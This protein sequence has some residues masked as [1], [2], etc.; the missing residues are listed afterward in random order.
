MAP[1]GGIIV[2]RRCTERCPVTT[3]RDRPSPCP[4]L[5]S[6]QSLCNS[7]RTNSWAGGSPSLRLWASGQGALGK[8]APST[9]KR[10]QSALQTNLDPYLEPVL[11]CNLGWGVCLAIRKLVLQPT[12]VNTTPSTTYLSPQREQ[13]PRGFLKL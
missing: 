1:Q 5:H 10:H 8:K 7:L 4:A 11:E 6:I 9:P 2:S 13:W 12:R 3:P